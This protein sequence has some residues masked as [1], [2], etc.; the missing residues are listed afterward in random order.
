ML[1]TSP[2]A[3][4]RFPFAVGHRWGWEYWQQTTSGAIALG[5][6][7]DVTLDEEWTDHAT[8]TDRVQ[9]ALDERL[10]RDLGV[11]AE[12]THRWAAS[13]TY[14]ESGLPVLREVRPRVWA[15]GGYS[16]T[17]NLVGAVAARAAARMALGTSTAN[18]FD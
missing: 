5:G 1:A 8:P 17:G 12:V 9:R 11:D 4:D 15:V 6:C 2:V 16:G 10:R 7:R 18:P 3:A 14:T 13:V